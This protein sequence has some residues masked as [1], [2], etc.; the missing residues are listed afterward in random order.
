M[1]VTAMLAKNGSNSS[2]TMPSTVVPAAI[3]TGRRRE[4][5]ASM[6]AV[7]RGTSAAI[8]RSI[9]STSTTAFL[10][11]MP[12]RL[13]RPSSA[14]KPKA[15]PVSSRPKLTPQMAMGTTAQIISG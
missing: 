14:M 11:S 13:S 12:V 5:E 1:M 4:A 10:I 3:V 9:S 8:C 2:G 6:M 7:R 15:W